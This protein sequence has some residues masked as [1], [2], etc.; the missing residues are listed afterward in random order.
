MNPSKMDIGF[1]VDALKN[2]LPDFPTFQMLNLDQLPRFSKIIR[3][4]SATRIETLATP[5][6]LLELWR[7]IVKTTPRLEQSFR[8]RNFVEGSRKILIFVKY[9]EKRYNIKDLFIIC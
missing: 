9:V 2:F 8:P 6:G 1:F 3:S 7:L 4:N 5:L